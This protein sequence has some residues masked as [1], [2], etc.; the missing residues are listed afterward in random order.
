LEFL[1]EHV[2][3]LARALRARRLRGLA[4]ID[5]DLALNAQQLVNRVR[6]K[7]DVL[8]VTRGTRLIRHRAG[9][10]HGID[11][12]AHA[13]DLEATVAWLDRVVENIEHELDVIDRGRVLWLTVFAA[14]LAAVAALFSAIGIGISVWSSLTRV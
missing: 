4:I 9:L 8:G 14:A 12:P 5:A 13:P 3:D 1:R 11:P 10:V 7:D 2:L 6:E